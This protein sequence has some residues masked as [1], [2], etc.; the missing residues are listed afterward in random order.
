MKQ[1]INPGQSAYSDIF[2]SDRLDLFRSTVQKSHKI[3]IVTHYDADGDAIGSSLALFHYL[4]RTG[5]FSIQVLTPNDYPT[6]LHWLPAHTEVKIYDNNPDEIEEFVSQCDL[7]IYVDFNTLSRVKKMQGVF[8]N[9]SANQIL[10]DHH[11]N[12]DAPCL[13]R[14][15]DTRPSSTSELIYYLIESLGDKNLLNKEIAEC[16]FTG[17]M[18]DTGCFSFNSSRPETW[19]AVAELLRRH[20]DKDAIFSQVYE[21][22]SDSRMRLM[23]YCLNEKMKVISEYN[24][25]FISLSLDE[26]RKFHFE[27]GDTEGFVNLPFS[28][29]GIKVTA[30]FIERDDHI[31]ISLRSKG[32]IAINRI[33][34]KHFNGGGHKNAAGGESMLNMEETISKFTSLLKVY[35]KELLQTNE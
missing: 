27:P 33:A 1:K 30:L 35:E 18:T 5:S 15:S 20:I 12:P 26:L 34:Q 24:T 11:P 14:F 29:N 8:E 2:S 19:Q 6:F 22:Y 9:I 3:T 13:L 10:I 16:L 4:N 31:K 17:I 7:I 28:V 25:A 21:N 23:G 32:N